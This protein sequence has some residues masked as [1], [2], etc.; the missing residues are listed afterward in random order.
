LG[1]VFVLADQDPEPKKVTIR[2]L[3]GTMRA[4]SLIELHINVVHQFGY[5]L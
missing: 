4:E 1:V 2:F 3:A 5:L